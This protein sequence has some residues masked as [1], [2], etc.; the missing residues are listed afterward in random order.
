[1]PATQIEDFENDEKIAKRNP[2]DACHAEIGVPAVRAH[3]E[4]AAKPRKL[5]KILWFMK[6][7]V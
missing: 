7:K 1:M 3:V 5:M 6:N 2:C 4:R